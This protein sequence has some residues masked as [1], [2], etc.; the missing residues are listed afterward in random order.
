MRGDAS[1]YRLGGRARTRGRG[2]TPP[3]AACRRSR[4]P[5]TARTHSQLRN[6]GVSG[7]PTS[8]FPGEPDLATF[9][10]PLKDER[11]PDIHCVGR[12]SSYKRH[13]S[14]SFGG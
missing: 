9:V 10:F 2:V 11:W 13:R 4:N 12:Q 14:G 1:P 8:A 6:T 3:S 5:H 7:A